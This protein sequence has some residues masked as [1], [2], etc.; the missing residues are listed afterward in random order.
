MIVGFGL[1]LG[2]T[3]PA[4][5]A[6]EDVPGGRWA[7]LAVPAT[8]K[9]GF[10]T[11][12][13]IRAG[14]AFT[15]RLA[16]ARYLTNQVLLNGSGVAAGDV[17]GDGWCDLYFCGMDG[18]NALYRNRGNWRFEDVTAAAG[19]ACPEQPS[20]GAVLADVD[21]D[22]D[23]DLLV[24]GIGAGTR[25]FQNDGRGRFEEV[26]QVAGL[27]GG[28]GACSMTLA[29]VD[30]D[31]D[32]DLYVVN[33][34]PTTF[35]DEPPKRFSVATANNRFELVAVDG[36]PV[37]TPELRGRFSVDRVTGV[38][39][40]GEAD[41]LYRNDGRGRFTS[42]DWSD[43]TFLDEDG[44]P[45]AVPYDWGLSAMFRDLDGDG[46]PD[47]YVCNDFHSPD[48]IWMNNGR[49]GFRA[50]ARLAV[51]QTSIFSMGLDVAD[52]DRDGHDDVFVADMFSRSHARR[53]VQLMDRQPAVQ[54]VGASDARPQYS[55]NTLL[56]SRGDGTYAEIAQYAGLE[57]SDWCWAPVFLDVDLDGFEDLLCVTGHV[58]DAQNIDIARRID[59]ITRRRKLSW[60]EQLRLR[61]LFERLEVPNYAFR[62]RGD[63]TFEEVGKAWGFDSRQVSQGIALADLDND[64]DLDVAINC[65]DDR[66]LLC[67]NESARPRVAVRLR[68]LAP[69]TRGIGARITV[70]DP[71]LPPQ[72]QEVM[73]GGRYVSSDD[74]VRVFAASAAEAELVIEVRWR[75]GRHSRIQSAGANHLYE[76]VEAAAL[77]P[78]SPPPH[79]TT[80][81]WFEDVSD[82][83][84][85]RHPETPFDDFH[86]QPLLPHKF[87][88]LG[89]GVSWFDVDADGWDDLIVASGRGGRMAVLRND[90]RG[91]FAPLPSPVLGDPVPRDQTAVL[92]WYP[93]PGQVALLAG[94]AN[95][96]DGR[97][98]GPVVRQYQIEAG[99][100]DD[101]LP[102]QRSSS[103]PLALAD[104]DGD[105]D[106]DLFVGGRVIAGRCPEP[107]SSLVLRN[108]VGTLRLDLE[109]SRGLADV[110]MVSDAVFTDLDAD[111]WPDLVLACQW[112]P[113]RV[114]RNQRG[115][116]EA[117]DP[118][119]VDG[120]PATARPSV[121]GRGDGLGRG[122]ERLSAWTGWWN[123]VTAG[124]FDGDG[125]MDL[126]AGNWGRN[127]KYQAHLGSPLHTY[128][129]DLN[130][131]GFVELVEAYAAP[132]LGTVVPLRDWSTLSRSLPFLL[133][134]FT[135]HTAFSTA[136][137]L[138][139]LGDRRSQVGDLPVRTLD[140][141]VLLN[142]GDRF[143]RSALPGTAQFSPIF[144]LAVGDFDGDGR[145]DLFAVQNLFAVA[146]LTS[147]CDGGV[148]IWLRGDGRGGF[149]P[150]PA[151][152]SGVHVHGEGRGLAVGDF[153]QDGRVD[154]AVGQNG[155]A[156]RL[157]RNQ[158][159]R[160]GLRV[161]L[162]G[163]PVNP[164]GIGASLHLV[165]ADGSRGPEREVRA[166]GGYWSQDS[167]I[168]V[169]ATAR[170]PRGLVVRWAGGRAVEVPVP[171][172][173]LRVTVSWR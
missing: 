67:R 45:S 163:P 126:A 138:D 147:R 1:A 71:D 57:A 39:E 102:G 73:A 125:R 173:A 91:G 41:V 155:E 70:R 167:A 88:Q 115:R 15:N 76:I 6:W 32:L 127:T 33:Y 165:Y 84:G 59:E 43:G 151:R 87:S 129:G 152:E 79:P 169:L 5:S 95:Y 13:P 24:T 74:P 21:G 46:A 117:W 140:S 23:L 50:I 52:V 51:R 172:G 11:L 7:A 35:R 113:V 104:V 101:G 89:P 116:F 9:T 48:R 90:G 66:P 171:D 29:D 120:A 65:L 159:G 2:A 16:E 86:Q 12:D 148:G 72:S 80:T 170:Q 83:L 92:G 156:T 56:G 10:T 53:Q 49:G 8:G 139:V 168:L 119:V 143:E 20:T 38:L 145:D 164:Q 106:L 55:R 85:H 36:R 109:A 64:G 4:L 93:R 131:D 136:S 114:Y 19:V 158:R 60:G 97:T 30:G 25:L 118:I 135:N 107:A 26:T 110:G 133:E 75:S 162:E 157:F 99:T 128:Y 142:R 112:G 137:V 98:N 22:G 63:L 122:P 154:M 108:D 105:G 40:N 132:E 81:P 47:L 111:G 31:G 34:R 58:R 77:E 42:V 68:G 123:S 160:P 121:Q 124:D 61:G 54:M 141:I 27:L 28:T 146:P 37:A 44:R 103:G 14:I 149:A 94:S 62:N 134:R 82:R 69:N 96:E 3:P 100:V 18:P 17:D 166:G 161:R 144:G 78:S 130:D 150:V 153:D